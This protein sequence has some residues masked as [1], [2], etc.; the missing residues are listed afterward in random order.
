MNYFKVKFQVRQLI[1]EFLE[2]E[3]NDELIAMWKAMTPSE[4]A[5]SIG[6][7]N[8]LSVQLTSGEKC[9]LRL[10]GNRQRKGTF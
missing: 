4:N 2:V 8:H 9:G 3:L 5:Q 1:Q 7:K 10:T 6:H